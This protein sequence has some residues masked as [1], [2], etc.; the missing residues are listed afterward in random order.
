MS[1]ASRKKYRGTSKSQVIK[2]KSRTPVTVEERHSKSLIG[3]VPIISLPKPT[4]VPNIQVINKMR[5]IINTG[6]KSQKQIAKE[7]DKGQSIYE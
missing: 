5:G 6:L 1:T 4:S 3:L 2:S 7:S